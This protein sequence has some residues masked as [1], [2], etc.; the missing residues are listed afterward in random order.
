M[1]D[2]NIK[3]AGSKA[4]RFAADPI[5]IAPEEKKK[6]GLIIGRRPAFRIAPA[7]WTASPTVGDQPLR[8]DASF[9]TASRRE[10]TP[11]FRRT[12]LTCER[13]VWSEM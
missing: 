1:Q 6:R 11:S 7:G 2:I 13:T 12:A 5:A 10:D 9:S 4:G 8:A 3:T